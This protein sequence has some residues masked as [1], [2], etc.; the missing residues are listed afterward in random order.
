MNNKLLELLA[1]KKG[2]IA[3]DF[4]DGNNEM[5]YESIL[6]MYKSPKTFN[7]TDV[8][9]SP[10]ILEYNCDVNTDIIIIQKCPIN[11]DFE[12]FYNL[13]TVGVNKG[14]LGYIHPKILI[15]LPG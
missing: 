2:L 10:H 6:K 12:A 5:I 8:Q 9:L 1:T 15:L 14:I 13:V 4:S 3:I 11:G 7:Y